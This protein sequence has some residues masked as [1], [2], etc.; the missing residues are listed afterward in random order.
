MMFARALC[1]WL[2]FKVS[3]SARYACLMLV[4][5]ALQACATPAGNLNKLAQEQGFS[6]ETVN[7]AGYKLL[8]YKNRQAVAGFPANADNSILHVYLEGD[9]SP[10]RHR[11]FIMADPTPRRPLMLEL[12]KLDRQP[13]VYLGRPC[14]NG[15]SMEK[16]CTNA[17]W[18]SGRYSPAVIES[19]A[20]GLNDLQRRHQASELWLFGHSGGGALAMLLAARLPDVTRIVT[21]AG[22]LDTQAWTRHHGYT[23]LFSSLN[24]VKQ[25]DLRKSVWQWHLLGGRDAVIP[26]PLVRPFIMRQSQASGFQFDRFSHGCCWQ[27]VWSEVLEALA[28]DEPKRI[29]ARQFK[30]PDSL[31]DASESR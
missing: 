2:G 5:L 7:A 29:P 9:G 6:R 27:L 14:Y 28:L 8:V 20:S 19:M 22:N 21:I 30:Y 13:S 4:C 1:E 24:P 23:P 3:A 17:L 18:T 10:W 15:T 12:M 31:L 16:P 26:P 25:P 11:V